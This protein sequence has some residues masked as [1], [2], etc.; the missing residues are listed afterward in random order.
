MRIAVTGA[1]GFIGSALCEELAGEHSV[2]ALT[3]NPHKSRFKSSADV[4]KWNPQRLDGWETC[5]DGIDAIVNLAG[6]N[7][8]SVK[9]DSQGKALILNSRTG[10]LK[11]LLE[12]V[13]KLAVKPKVIV[14]A[15]GIDYYP[16]AQEQQFFE[17]SQTGDGFL[18]EVCRQV[19]SFA[20]EFAKLNIRP[21]IIRSGLV[22]DSSG[23]AL[24]QMMMPIKFYI[25]GWWGSGKQWISWISLADEVSA[26]KF[27]IENENLS[28]AFNLT[29]PQPLCN[30]EFFQ[31][32][33]V[34][35]NKP[36]R[37]AIP[38]FVLKFMFGEMA[39]EV[40][41]ASRRVY[42]KK[43]TDAGYMF[44]NADLKNTLESLKL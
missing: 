22:L 37:L 34:A 40:L 36:C 43:L 13:K 16:S 9:W 6:A 11:I 30:R 14:L 42:P 35:M 39:K 15:S 33:A 32:L 3:R 2:I 41:L 5:L 10:S 26:I 12:A 4:L 7:I 18:A 38:A 29:S 24:P 23:G 20:D 17:D 31:K 21:V 19:E 1:T 8:A 27:L 44:K 28:G 25:G